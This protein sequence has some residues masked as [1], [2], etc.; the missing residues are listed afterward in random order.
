MNYR[1]LVS[2]VALSCATTSAMGALLHV[3]PAS[4]GG[5]GGTWSTA[6]SNLVEVVRSASAGDVVWVAAGSYSGN[7]RIPSG[8]TV[9]GGFR[10]DETS[11]ELRNPRRY[12]TQLQPASN[13]LP[14]VNFLS[15][16]DPSTLE[17]SLELPL[18]LRAPVPAWQASTVTSSP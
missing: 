5:D 2:L 17:L 9:L 16:T 7:V 1:Q 13:G 11:A 12:A 10:G 8:V 15:G 6:S 4:P 14:T 3:S 18:V